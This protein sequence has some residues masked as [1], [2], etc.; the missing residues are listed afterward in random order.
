M[1]A[2]PI[3]APVLRAET[4]KAIA[5]LVSKGCRVIVTPD[6]AIHVDP[7]KA[8]VANPFDTVDWSK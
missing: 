6:G 2:R 4:R 3:T 1:G 8:E 7:P 5:D